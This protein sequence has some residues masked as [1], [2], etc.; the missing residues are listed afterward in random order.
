M[1]KMNNMLVIGDLIIDIFVDGNVSRINPEAPNAVLDVYKKK[2]SLGGVGNV[3]DYFYHK[4]EKINFIL[5][6]GKKN[7]FKEIFFL[8][9]KYKKLI[10]KIFF[11]NIYNILK[12]RYSSN[13]QYILRVDEFKKYS[14]SSQFQK[15]IINFLKNKNIQYCCISDYNKGCINGLFLSKIID[16]CYNRKIKIIIDTKKSKIDILKNIFL[17]TPNLIELINL[18]KLSQDAS[19]DRIIH[20][21]IYFK[22]NKNIE[23][24]LITM[25][26][27][28]AILINKQQKVKKF[29]VQKKHIFDVTGA[30]DVLFSSIIYNLLKKTT[31]EKSIKNA[32]KEATDSVEIFGKISENKLEIQL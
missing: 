21:A 10:H 13:N 3:I 20:Q 27:E 29:T 30:G 22:K 23:N 2:L 16:I 28:G 24:I 14:V 1:K 6:V 32:L 9:N 5:F 8:T 17:I 19:L 4:K 11:G 26:K 15:F 18:C 25:S 31:L 12:F 7:Y